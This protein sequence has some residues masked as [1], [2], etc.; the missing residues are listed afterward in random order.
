MDVANRYILLLLY[1][2]I[3]CTY[4]QIAGDFANKDVLRRHE[5]IKKSL[6]KGTCQKSS[7]DNYKRQWSS[8]GKSF[9]ESRGTTLLPD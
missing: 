6:E 9:L 3:K 5:R 7:F 2:N 4:S 8:G 1:Y